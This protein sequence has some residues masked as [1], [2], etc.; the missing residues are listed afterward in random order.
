MLALLPHL[1]LLVGRKLTFTRKMYAHQPQVAA[2]LLEINLQ[3]RLFLKMQY[4][5]FMYLDL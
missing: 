3:I 5:M 2:V 4:L 1:V